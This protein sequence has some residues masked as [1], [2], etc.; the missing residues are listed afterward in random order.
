MSILDLSNDLKNKDCGYFGL[1]DELISEKMHTVGNNNWGKNLLCCQK[2]L[3][4]IVDIEGALCSH[5]WLLG[6]FV[7]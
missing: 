7:A 1:F 4:L 2:V 5:H 3:T 6:K